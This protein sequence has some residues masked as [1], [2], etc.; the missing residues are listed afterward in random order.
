MEF[1]NLNPDAA[2]G[3]RAAAGDPMDIGAFGE[4]FPEQEYEAE[5][6]CGPCEGDQLNAFGNTLRCFNCQGYGHRIEQCPSAR[7]TP[8]GPGKGGAPGPKGGK[9]KGKPTNMPHQ[10]LSKGAQGGPRFGSCWTCGGPHFAEQCPKGAGKSG[11]KGFNMIGTH[12]P[13][14]GEAQAQPQPRILGA[15][16]TVTT[17]NRFAALISD[18][19]R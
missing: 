8:G 18:D 3:K 5:D 2:T 1:A 4:Y 12:W 15:F 10:N 16:R 9:G 13:T 14:P 19:E 17:S 7:R 6:Q 11:G